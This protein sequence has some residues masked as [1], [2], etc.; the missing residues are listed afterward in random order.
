MEAE[1]VPVKKT[2]SELRNKYDEIAELCRNSPEPVV[3]TRNGVNE[4]AVM[5]YEAYE[6]FTERID[7]LNSQLDGLH[8]QIKDFES[9]FE[10]YSIMAAGRA[11]A[12]AR[13]SRIQSIDNEF[14]ELIKRFKN[15]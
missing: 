15:K 1:T 6:R 13:Q 3:I 11:E 2:I 5:S 9:K 12:F 14:D 8:E 7:A 10:M 4:L